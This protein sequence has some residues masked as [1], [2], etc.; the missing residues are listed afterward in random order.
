[1][2]MV[3]SWSC[4]SSHCHLQRSCPILQIFS[5]ELPSVRLKKVFPIILV[6]IEPH[7]FSTRNKFLTNNSNIFKPLRILL[8]CW[9]KRHPRRIRAPPWNFLPWCHNAP[10]SLQN[11]KLCLPEFLQSYANVTWWCFMT[12]VENLLG[13]GWQELLSDEGIFSTQGGSKFRI[14]ARIK[15]ELS[16]PSCPW[17]RRPS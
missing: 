4:S 8:N 11:V 2:G 1:M 12:F 9:P 13:V 16:V 17:S 15:R 3:L 5:G 7:W 10:Y 14:M 6:H